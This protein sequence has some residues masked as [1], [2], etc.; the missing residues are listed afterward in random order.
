MGFKGDEMKVLIAISVYIFLLAF[1]LLLWFGICKRNKPPATQ[2]A[3]PDPKT[4]GN[5]DKVDAG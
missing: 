5:G 4:D 3:R 1:I 2:K